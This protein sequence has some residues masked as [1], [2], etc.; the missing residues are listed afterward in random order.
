MALKSDSAVTQRD[1]G[2]YISLIAVVGFLF[3]SPFLNRPSSLLL[4][5]HLQ[6]PPPLVVQIKYV[7]NTTTN[8]NT[9]TKVAK[10]SLSETAPHNNSSVLDSVLASYVRICFF[11]A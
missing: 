7:I 1:S 6:F 5:P 4:L 8:T 9:V 11:L 3:T 10:M 2:L